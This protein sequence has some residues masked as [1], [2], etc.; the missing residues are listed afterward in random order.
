MKRFWAQ[1]NGREKFLIV[2]CMLA[3]VIAVPMLLSP[4]PES[5]GKLLT[6]AKAQQEY[7]SKVRDK[8]RMEAEVDRLKP[9]IEKL[10]YKE[11]PEK[12]L[13][14]VIRSLQAQAKKAGIHLRE[15]KPLRARKM[16]T[17]TKVPV[18]VRFA[19]RFDQSLPFLYAV[20]DPNNKLVVEKF[21]ISS[22]DSK[23]KTVDVEVQL[24]LYTSNMTDSDAG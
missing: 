23:S 24:A 15:I 2:A 9:K 11:A 19:S 5:G 22:P 14:R 6:A 1:R 13:P 20:E 3:V 10:V 8:E 12:V 21:S 17:V 16:I 18:T 7:D 4:P